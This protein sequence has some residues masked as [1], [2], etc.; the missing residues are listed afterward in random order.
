MK[1]PTKPGA[2][3]QVRLLAILLGIIVLAWVSLEDKSVTLALLLAAAICMLAAAEWLAYSSHLS[4]GKGWLAYPLA[5]LVGGA[6]TA[7]LLMA[8]KTGLHG[9]TVPDYTPAQMGAVLT[10]FPI[11]AGAGAIIGLGAG[12]WSKNR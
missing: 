7:L 12:I 9:H 4:T 2:P 5:G 11:W 3:R 1:P 8:I 6:A 10:S